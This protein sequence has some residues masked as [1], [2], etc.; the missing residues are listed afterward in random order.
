VSLYLFKIDDDYVLID[1]GWKMSEWSKKFFSTLKKIGITLKDIKYCILTHKHTDHIGLLKKFKRRNPEIQVLMHHFTNENIQWESNPKNHKEIENL[2]RE[3]GKLLIKYGVSEEEVEKF[4]TM[5]TTWAKMTSYEEADRI[6]HDGDE[7]SFKTNKLKIIWTPGHSLGHI[8]VFDN[9]KRFL[10]SGDHILSRI[11]PH[12]GN[13]MI[14]PNI[15]KEHDFTNILK[16]YLKSLDVI[17]D[18]NPKIIFPAHQ[19]VIFNPHERILEIKKH[20]E[21]RL[22]EISKMIENNPMTPNKISQIHFGE[23]DQLNSYLGLSEILG[24]LIYLEEEGIV[25]RIEKSGKYL[26]TC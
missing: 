20:H 1:A 22:T 25:N 2:A 24:H 10:F 8:N 7:I 26:F 4:A 19:E 11:T 12:I 9:D 21:T 14:N 5:M 15:S 13:F 3:K 17:D 23:L 6:L 18:L 16:I